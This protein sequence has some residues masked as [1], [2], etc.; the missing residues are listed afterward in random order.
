M[1]ILDRS[2]LH[3][4]TKFHHLWP[5]FAVRPEI[6][7]QYLKTL[8]GGKEQ[9]L[10]TMEADRGVHWIKEGQKLVTAEDSGTAEAL[11]RMKA[12]IRNK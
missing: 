2:V 12:R 10:E 4:S 7:S 8:R 9:M 3:L 11:R 5:S 1:G 6:I